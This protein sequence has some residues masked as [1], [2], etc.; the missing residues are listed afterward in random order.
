MVSYL[1][2]MYGD[3]ATLDNDWGYEWHPK[4][5]GDHSHRH[6]G[7]DGRWQGQRM[8]CVGQNPAT[9]LNGTAQRAAMRKLE[10][11]VVKDNW[12]TET[13]M[14]WKNAPEITNGSVD[15]DIQ[16]E[17][18]FFPAT[19]VGE[20]DGSFT[21]TQRMLQ[22]HSKAADPPAT[23]ERIRGSITSSESGSRRMPAVP[24]RATPGSGISSGITNRIPG[25]RR[26][27]RPP[28]SLTCSRFCAR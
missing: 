6:H 11:L 25:H 18:F 9:S 23:A 13:A 20:Y 3:A 15:Q 4:V 12:L 17:V 16:T 5:L 21:N 1:K 22:W 2:S 8:F 10:W 14:Y 24:I 28:A 27:R 26:P 19:Q 7:G